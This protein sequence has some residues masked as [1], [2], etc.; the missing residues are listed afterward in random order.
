[1][2]EAQNPSP[3]FTLYEHMFILYT[4]SIGKGGDLN[5]R[6][7]E[8][9]ISSQSWVENTNMTLQSINT[10]TKSLYRSIFLDET[11]CFDVYSYLVHGCSYS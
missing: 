10:A 3:P 11:F 5:Q 6:E 4:Y 7:G 8:R 1:M 2:S 9:G